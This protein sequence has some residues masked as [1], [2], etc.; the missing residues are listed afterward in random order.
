[1]AIVDF[2]AHHGKGSQQKDSGSVS[3]SARHGTDGIVNSPVLQKAA[4][5]CSLKRVARVLSD[6]LHQALTT[7]YVDRLLKGSFRF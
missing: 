4:N 2:G 6:S 1:V 5:A 3:R 7:G